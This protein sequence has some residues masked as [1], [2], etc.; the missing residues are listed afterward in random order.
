MIGGYVAG[1]ATPADHQAL[2]ARLDSARQ[3]AISGPPSAP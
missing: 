2:A 1:V 3:R